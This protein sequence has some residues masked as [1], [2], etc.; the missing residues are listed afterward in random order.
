[1]SYSLSS[2]STTGKSSS[3]AFY[4]SSSTITTGK[5]SSSSLKFSFLLF[6][7]YPNIW[8]GKSSSLSF[9]SSSSTITTGKSSPSSNIFYN[10]KNSSSSSSSEVIESI[11][12]SVSPEIYEI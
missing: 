12:M 1:L 8:A 11:G 6:Y 4:S 2:I 9:Y 10:F 5:S 3:L 7:F